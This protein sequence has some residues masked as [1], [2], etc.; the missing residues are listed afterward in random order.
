[1]LNEGN[2]GYGYKAS[3]FS[4][5]FS[6]SLF[7]PGCKLDP[8]ALQNSVHFYQHTTRGAAA[9]SKQESLTEYSKFTKRFAARRRAVECRV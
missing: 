6:S 8:W 2:A 1:M 4:F 5:L 3:L 9:Y 7:F